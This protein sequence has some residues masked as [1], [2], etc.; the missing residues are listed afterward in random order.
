M[1]ENEKEILE[2]KKEKIKKIF[3]DKYNLGLFGVLMTAFLIRIYYFFLTKDQAHWWDTLAYGSLAKHSILGLWSTNEFI[4]HEAII[5][6]P[7]LPLIWSWLIRLNISEIG[8]ILFLEFL[9]SLISVYLVYLIGKELYNK[10]VGLIAS[11]VI[12]VSWLNLFYAS[13]IM[14]DIPALFF[15][16]LSIYYFLKSYKQ[17]QTKLFFLSI[18]FLSLAVLTRNVSVVIGGVYLLFLF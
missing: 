12:A 13:R 10:K 3:E 9:P 1:E 5:R 4:L 7:L 14:T 6:A 16:L 15:S 2:V 11:F 8:V 18:F 17:L